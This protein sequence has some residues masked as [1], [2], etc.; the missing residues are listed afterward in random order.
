[1][2]NSN[3][4]YITPLAIMTY[5][6][7]EGWVE[8][9]K[10]RNGKGVQFVSP[11]HKVGVII[12][13]DST[14][15]DYDKSVLNLI[16]TI[17]TFKKCSISSIIV[18]LTSPLSDILKW[19]VINVCTE[20]GTIPLGQA[21]ELIEAIKDIISASI[22]DVRDPVHKHGKIRTKSTVDLLNSYS[23][24]QS[25]RGSYIINV[26]CP[27]SN[28]DLQLFESP[29]ARRTNEHILSSIFSIKSEINKNN[30]TKIEEDVHKGIY[31]VNFLESLIDISESSNFSDI[32]LSV[33]WCKAI[34]TSIVQVPNTI[35]IEPR[36]VDLIRK[37][38]EKFS[39]EEVV[40][41]K[42]VGKICALKADPEVGER[43]KGTVTVIAL[44]DGNKS[45][46][47]N[48]ELN[49]SDFN[50]AT[51]AFEGGL[52]VVVSGQ[53]VLGG[54]IRNMLNPVF[55]ILSIE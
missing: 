55:K 31:S 6:E 53:L 29:I 23:L 45:I 33:D 18:K 52:N 32:E 50:E 3:I 46:K 49:V 48:L 39:M 4:K 42:Y 28:M 26:L 37:I 35:M 17:S 13:L 44:D 1:M 7:R 21:S 20:G 24:G 38:V 34:D 5:L 16:E 51:R 40:T 8:N 10:L 12:P 22:C 36:Q 30:V 9:Y 41:Q 15:S 11:D 47:I 25:E 14:L 27:L 43:K 19:R 54:K 2:I